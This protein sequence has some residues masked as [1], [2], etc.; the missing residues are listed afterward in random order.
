MR[1]T[2]E[3]GVE[4]TCSNRTDGKFGYMVPDW[5]GAARFGKLAR[6]N[7]MPHTVTNGWSSS[8]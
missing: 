2:P 5:D 1:L 8:P 6:V 7:V 3:A 4:I